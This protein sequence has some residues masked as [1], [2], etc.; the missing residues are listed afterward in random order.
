MNTLETKESVT[1]ESRVLNKYE[2][3]LE[4]AIKAGERMSE[5]RIRI[6]KMM[7]ELRATK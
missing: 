5:E 4:E 6:N 7:T 3:A 2:Q 1:K